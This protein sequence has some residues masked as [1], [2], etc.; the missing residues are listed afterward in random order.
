MKL[1]EITIRPTSG[2][3]TALKGD[4]LFG[5]FCWQVWH[6][7]SLV[8][9][10]L[11]EQIDVYA[12]KPFVI[13]SSAFPKL[14]SSSK[15]YILKRPDLPLSLLFPENGEALCRNRLKEEKSHRKKKWMMLADDLRSDLSN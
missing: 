14:D 9:G 2:F 7:P 12:E 13:F 4:T 15:Y 8:K 10:G 6:K 11:D 5:H 1:Y 3:G